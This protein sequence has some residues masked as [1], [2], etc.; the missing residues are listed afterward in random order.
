MKTFSY[1]KNNIIHIVMILVLLGMS[2]LVYTIAKTEYE[3]LKNPTSLK[4]VKGVQNHLVWD[5]NGNCYFIRPHNEYTSY[6]IA[7]PDCNKI[8]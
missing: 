1:V 8:R 7:V 5:V 6:L 4:E 3:E 2:Y